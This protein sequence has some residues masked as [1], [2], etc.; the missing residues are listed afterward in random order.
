MPT[1]YFK[2]EVEGGLSASFQEVWGLDTDGN[3]TENRHSGSPEFS[4][5]KMPGL[6]KTSE[7]TLKNGTVTGDTG[8]IE[9]CS[10]N[11]ANAK[12]HRTVKIMLMNEM[13]DA[14]IVWALTNAFPKLVQ[15]P[16]LTASSSDMAVE[17]LILSYEGLEIL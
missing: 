11:K 13:G 1:F 10:G 14:E 16:S 12:L 2:V 9:W 8:L 7:L 4:H 5:I 17:T 15:G 3:A 6:K